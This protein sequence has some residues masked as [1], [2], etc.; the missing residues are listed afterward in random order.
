MRFIVLC[1]KARTH[2]L[3]VNDLLGIGVSWGAG[4]EG[5]CH[6]SIVSEADS[7]LQLGNRSCPGLWPPREKNVLACGV[8]LGTGLWE[9]FS[10][11]GRQTPG[12]W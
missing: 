4:S 8:L 2:T 6:T 3:K 7:M 9:M 10:S 1:C 11:Q 5:K 12:G